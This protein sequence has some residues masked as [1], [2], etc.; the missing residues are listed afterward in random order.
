MYYLLYV[1]KVSAECT[2]RDIAD[3]LQTSRKNNP[4]NA[5]TGILVY[6]NPEFL[7]FL[8]GP[9]DAVKSL[10]DRI[11]RDG[12]HEAV[13][14]INQGEIEERVFPGWDMGFA[15]EDNLQP[16]QKKW[17]L[18]KLALFSLAENMDECMD[19]VRAFIDTPN[20][21]TISPET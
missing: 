4:F 7:Q 19:F 3:I 14:I 1:S 13:K 10:Y 6:K 20:L 8:E 11:E 2:R 21:D 12:R 18:D 16:L 15:S 17:E 9:E 5:V